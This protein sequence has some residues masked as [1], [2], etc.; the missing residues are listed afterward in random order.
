MSIYLSLFEFG[1]CSKGPSLWKEYSGYCRR[2]QELATIH[3]ITIPP[4]GPDTNAP[5]DVQT[6]WRMCY[7]LF[8]V[9][10]VA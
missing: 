1:V 9:E 4:S 8:R 2:L 7:F 3:R 10:S 6:E 5:A